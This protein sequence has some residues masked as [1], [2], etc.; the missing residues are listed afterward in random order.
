MDEFESLLSS[1]AWPSEAFW[2]LF[3]LQALREST[4]ERPILE[5]GCGDG[6]FTALLLDHVDE[7]LD[8][9][10]RA[11]AKAVPDVNSM[12]QCSA[13]T[14]GS[15]QIFA[16]LTLRPCLPTVF[17]NTSMACPACWMRAITYSLR[18]VA[19]SRRSRWW[20]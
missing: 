6:S 10:P 11:V 5:L 2:R 16:G 9:N 1:C 20:R 4:F 18:V 3:E 15:W 17:S 7:G 12:G 8:L 19:S 14:Q 13:S